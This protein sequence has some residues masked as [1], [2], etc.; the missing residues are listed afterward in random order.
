[1]AEPRRRSPL[2]VVAAVG[3]AIAVVVLVVA[4]IGRLI[5]AAAFGGGT[6]GLEAALARASVEAISNTAW[7]S[8]AVV[9]LAVSIGALAAL[10]LHR[11]AVPGRR[12]L[13][14]VLL[15]P[16]LTPPFVAALGWVQAYAPAALTDDLFGMS[17]AALYGP[18]GIVAVLVVSSVPL[19]LLV[20][21][22]ALDDR[23]EPDLDRAARASGAT[24]AVALRTVTLPLLRPALLAAS[25]LIFATSINAFG[26]PAVLGIPAGFTTITTRIYQD[27]VFSADDAAFRRVIVLA[28]LLA[29]AGLVVVGLFDRWSHGLVPAERT[30]S[31]S[32]T[33]SA[34]GE[35][36][37]WIVAA[38]LV[39]YLVLTTIVP[40]VAL[41]LMSLTR[42]VGLAPLPENLT[43]DNF[44]AV[45]GPRTG[46]AVARS[47]GFAVAAA[48]LTLL[49]AGIVV[50]LG[51]RHGARAATMAATLMFA[52][53]GSTVAVGVLLAYGGLLRD[54]LLIILLAYL[55]KL[56]AVALRPI[57]GSV[58]R[59]PRDLLYA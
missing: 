1:M 29:V 53:P 59:L 16:L 44:A 23:A 34:A 17:V 22:A 11:L 55:A 25:V 35:R 12:A 51:R 31:G 4:P 21:G 6:A 52:L 19:A 56:W 26:V 7:T 18:I 24:R 13:R 42:A 9:V 37:A 49:L 54:T 30:G 58:E 2:A 50:A 32:G 14:I 33:V 3:A 8:G 41:V 28:C 48:T 10:A 45:I 20:V 38:L 5:G 40:F 43:F 27:L 47:A 57:A 36:S 15:L 46:G 39:A